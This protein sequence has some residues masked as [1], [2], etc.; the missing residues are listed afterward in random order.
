M[1]IRRCLSLSKPSRYRAHAS[2][3]SAGP[4]VE[5]RAAL[6]SYHRG[7]ACLPRESARRGASRGRQR[8]RRCTRRNRAWRPACPG[9]LPICTVTVLRIA[10]GVP[11]PRACPQLGFLDDRSEDRV[12]RR[13]AGSH[14]RRVGFRA[15]QSGGLPAD[16]DV[17]SHGVRP[18]W[19]ARPA[20]PSRSGIAT[21]RARPSS[22]NGSPLRAGSDPYCAASRLPLLASA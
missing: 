16:T 3:W 18:L 12:G 19:I 17:D 20:I 11:A 15:C 5:G 6:P 7:G 21:C 9:R 14:A 2:P 13:A 10:G 4:S 1:L 22:P 8:L